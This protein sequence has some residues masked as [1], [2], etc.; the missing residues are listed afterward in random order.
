[1]DPS[2]KLAVDDNKDDK[3][4]DNEDDIAQHKIKFPEGKLDPLMEPLAHIEEDS[5]TTKGKRRIHEDCFICINP[6]SAG[7]GVT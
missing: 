3:T 1:M 6:I 7:G 5:L 2:E 4:A